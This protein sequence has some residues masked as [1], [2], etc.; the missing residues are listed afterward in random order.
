MFMA[1]VVAA[2]AIG[3]LANTTIVADASDVVLTTAR[4][5]VGLM[6]LPG[7]PGQQSGNAAS[8]KLKIALLAPMPMA[9]T[10]AA[11]AKNPGARPNVRA[12]K[13]RSCQR[14]DMMVPDDTGG[15]PI[16]YAGLAGAR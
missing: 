2:G 12:A 15:S 6:Q 14:V 8:T 4:S 5:F 3:A 13:R 1:S 10:T 16:G 7:A 11:R 9:S